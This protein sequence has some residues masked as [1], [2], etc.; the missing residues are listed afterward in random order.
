MGSF[1]MHC[2]RTR[3]VARSSA[4]HA[5]AADQ[6]GKTHDPVERLTPSRQ[7][8]DPVLGG[9]DSVVVRRPAE[10]AASVVIST[11]IV[12]KGLDKDS[13]P[14]LIGSAAECGRPP[15]VRQL[16]GPPGAGWAAARLSRTGKFV[17]RTVGRDGHG[18]CWTGRS[19]VGS[20]RRRLWTSGLWRQ[21]EQAAEAARQPRRLPTSWFSC[22]GNLSDQEAGQS[23]H[24]SP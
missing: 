3:Q 11:R 4:G 6:E 1:A 8:S 7:V 12:N 9:P 20:V 2:R 22:S 13:A 5:A 14:S 16:N 21:H 19:I 10:S 17:R 24:N 18:N 15:C 23:D